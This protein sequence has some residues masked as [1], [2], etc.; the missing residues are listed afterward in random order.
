MNANKFCMHA[1]VTLVKVLT[2]HSNK[3]MLGV[4]VYALV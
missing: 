1:D 2:F 4:F 3:E